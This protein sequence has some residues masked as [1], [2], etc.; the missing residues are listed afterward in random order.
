MEWLTLLF[1]TLFRWVCDIEGGDEVEC[2]PD[3]D[4]D[5]FTWRSLCQNI[6]QVTWTPLFDRSC[7]DG[8]ELQ[9]AMVSLSAELLFMQSAPLWRPIWGRLKG[10]R[11][12]AEPT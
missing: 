1:V 5:A 10:S 8:L 4:L 12:R 3:D 7:L 9:V 2:L 6:G 11:S